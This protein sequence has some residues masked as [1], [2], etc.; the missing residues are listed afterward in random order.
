MAYPGIHLVDYLPAAMAH[1]YVDLQIAACHIAKTHPRPAY[2]QPLQ[3]ILDTAKHKYLRKYAV[4]AARANG[5][6][7][8]YDADAPFV[9]PADR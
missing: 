8:K 3:T 6:N 1:D 2:R 5:I 9:G 7:A 4:D